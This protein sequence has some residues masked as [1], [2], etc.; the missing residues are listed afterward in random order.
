VF[1]YLSIH[2][3]IVILTNLLLYINFTLGKSMKATTAK[4]NSVPTTPYSRPQIRPQATQTSNLPSSQFTYVPFN[5]VSLDDIKELVPIDSPKSSGTARH[6]QLIRYTQTRPIAPG[7][8][9]PVPLLQ[10]PST[11]VIDTGLE[12][13]TGIKK[14]P[15]APGSARPVSLLKQGSTSVIDTGLEQ[16]TGVY[17]KKRPIAPGSARPVSLLKQGST[18]VIDTGLEQPTGVYKKPP[19]APGSARPVLLLKQGSTSVI[20][21]GLEQPTG[22]KKRPIAPGSARP[23][24]LLKQ[25][26]TSVT[27]TG[28]E[29]PTGVYTKKPPIAPGSAKPVPLLQ[30]PSTDTGL[31]QPT[32]DEPDVEPP[33]PSVSALKS[34]MAKM[35][36]T[37]KTDTSA[38][39]LDECQW[40]VSL[41]NEKSTPISD[42]PSPLQSPS[43][44]NTE[45]TKLARPTPAGTNRARTTFT[46]TEEEFRNL[47]LRN[48][49]EILVF[50]DF[51][52]RLSRGA[53][54]R[55]KNPGFPVATLEEF[56]ALNIRISEDDEFKERVVRV[57]GSLYF[58]LFS[59]EII[60][61]ILGHI[62]SFR[63]TWA[64]QQLGTEFSSNAGG[65]RCR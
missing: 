2:H 59:N 7:S 35:V 9:K 53:G 3:K 1:Y 34:G 5:E 54:A 52:A 58:F 46:G 20:D 11:S 61:F 43:L 55:N 62:Y 45:Q 26:S 51:L 38:Q 27:D 63:K 49:S 13:P 60:F 47:V 25:G 50:L 37:P 31:E 56:L 44:A 10:Q 29:Q 36:L 41:R 14:R 21:T 64:E 18:S 23:V 42:S 6:Y 15:I 39:L 65:R 16:P 8:A 22:I 28:L 30:Q 48:F 40:N 17:I 12:Q 57:F 4:I 33:H 32:L 19:I 24:S